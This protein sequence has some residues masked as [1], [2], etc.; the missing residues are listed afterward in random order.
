MMLIAAEMVTIFHFRLC[1]TTA[2]LILV[3]GA[4]PI[5]S[6]TASP[7]VEGGDASLIMASIWWRLHATHNFVH[8]RA[9]RRQCRRKLAESVSHENMIHPLATSSKSVASLPRN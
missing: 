8:N 6:V 1:G 7:S 4:P 3:I 5:G 2:A 9:R